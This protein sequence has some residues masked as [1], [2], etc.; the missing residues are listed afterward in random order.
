MSTESSRILNG[1][2]IAVQGEKEWATSS[3]KNFKVT[4][5]RLNVHK[6]SGGHAS[7]GELKSQTTKKKIS[8]LLILAK[9][10]AATTRD[11]NH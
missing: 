7:G 2:F 11:V 4:Y 9:I 5:D 10:S 1:D 6:G 3:C 8:D